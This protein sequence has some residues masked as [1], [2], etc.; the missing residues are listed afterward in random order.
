MIVS[1]G[2]GSSLLVTRGYGGLTIF[3]FVSSP[4]TRKHP[5]GVL[6]VHGAYREIVF[7][8]IKTAKIQYA[9]GQIGVIAYQD[10]TRSIPCWDIRE[11][12]Y[13]IEFRSIRYKEEKRIIK[14]WVT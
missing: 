8:V 4:R 2:Y 12:R 3:P 11:A 14:K 6:T 1:R 5:V 13:R 7:S 9:P 10:E